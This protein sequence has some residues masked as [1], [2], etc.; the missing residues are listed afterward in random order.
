MPSDTHI[1]KKSR[2]NI[3]TYSRSFSDRPNMLSSM[4]RDIENLPTLCMNNN[5]T[6]SPHET[7]TMKRK[8]S[9]IKDGTNENFTSL[10]TIFPREG[11]KGCH[12][13][14]IVSRKLPFL[15]SCDATKRLYIGFG[16]TLVAAT[17]HYKKTHITLTTRAPEF[18]LTQWFLYRV[19]LHLGDFTY[20]IHELDDVPSSPNLKPTCSDYSV[21]NNSTASLVAPMFF[22]Q[23][24]MVSHGE[25]LSTDL[26]IGPSHPT[27]TKKSLPIQY[28]AN[29]NESLSHH[30][31]R[32]P[33]AVISPQNPISSDIK[34][35]NLSSS[36]SF[37]RGPTATLSVSPPRMPPTF[38]KVR[39]INDINDVIREWTPIDPVLES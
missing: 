13:T 6:Q 5:A 18:R 39:F 22:V 17:S 37:Q 33:L 20:T 34:T 23:P 32:S 7:G 14:V 30:I 29:R 12:I 26:P 25:C 24:I 35:V 19:P 1:M 4:E 27:M 28:L 21:P 2:N 9:M 31:Y 15:L 8:S 10:A 16:I 3:L 11:G 36:S 38:A